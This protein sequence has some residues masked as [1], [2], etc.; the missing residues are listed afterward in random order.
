MR[1]A[2][3]S[4]WQLVSPFAAGI[5]LA[6]AVVSFIVGLYYNTMVAW[7]LLYLYG[8]SS[9]VK[10]TRLPFA[11]CPALPQTT[12]HLTAQVPAIA[13]PSNETE[14][15]VSKNTFP[16]SRALLA[17]LRQHVRTSTPI[18]LAAHVVCLARICRQPRFECSSVCG[19]GGGGGGARDKAASQIKRRR[20]VA[21][22]MQLLRT[23]APARL[24]GRSAYVCVCN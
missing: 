13:A 18:C 12:A 16:V 6:S 8:A 1:K 7:T 11:E 20:D 22:V 3:I 15:Q 21:L 5:G 4:C 17:R 9:R 23:Q 19:S 2:A 24:P 14:C 10:T